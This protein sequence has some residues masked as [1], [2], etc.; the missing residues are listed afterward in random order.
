MSFS[1]LSLKRLNG[2]QW[3]RLEYTSVAVSWPAKS[4]MQPRLKNIMLIRCDL[5]STNYMRTLIYIYVVSNYYSAAVLCQRSHAEPPSRPPSHLRCPHSWIPRYHLGFSSITDSCD[6]EFVVVTWRRRH[7]YYGRACAAPFFLNLDSYLFD[8]RAILVSLGTTVCRPSLHRSQPPCGDTTDEVT[9][10]TI[11]AGSW[12]SKPIQHLACAVLSQGGLDK[13]CHT[14]LGVSSSYWIADL[15]LC[16]VVCQGL[17]PVPG[18]HL[19][20]SGVEENWHHHALCC[21]G[22]YYHEH[23]LVLSCCSLHSAVWCLL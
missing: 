13:R 22:V 21:S 9:H 11:Q 17:H 6:T 7:P 1:V 2:F 23:E 3:P 16:G 5:A 14:I 4:M 8:D 18:S 10:A 19:P 12:P 15:H 20:R